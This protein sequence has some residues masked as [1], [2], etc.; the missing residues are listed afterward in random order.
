M[1]KSKKSNTKK[2]VDYCYVVYDSELMKI[3]GVHSNLKKIYLYYKDWFM[4]D[5]K[6]ITTYLSLYQRF[7]K[8]D[9]IDIYHSIENPIIL[10]VSKHQVF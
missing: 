1:A 3:E 10:R 6:Q 5:G 8:N 4:S 9:L 2:R 7:I